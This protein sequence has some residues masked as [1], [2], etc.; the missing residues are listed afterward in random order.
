MEAEL[1]GTAPGAYTGAERKARIGQ[2]RIELDEAALELLALQPWPGNA[3]EL[4]NLLERAQLQT[5][6][7]PLNRRALL[8]LLD[9]SPPAHPQSAPA[10]QCLGIARA[11]L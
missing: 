7:S 5:D 11:S 4:G 10:A 2:P 3:R 8:A 1:F 9:G 6:G